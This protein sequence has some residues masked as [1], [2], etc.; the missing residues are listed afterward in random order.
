MNRGRIQ[1]PAAIHDEVANENT[2]DMVNRLTAVPKSTKGQLKYFDTLTILVERYED[3]TEG[4]VQGV[5][6]L[7]ALRFLMTDRD[8]TASDLGRLLGDRSLGPKILNGERALSEAHIKTLA[9]HFKVSP[10]VLLD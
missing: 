2:M 5:A 10:A 9:K 4:A 3:E 7:A 6:A 1:P 8:L